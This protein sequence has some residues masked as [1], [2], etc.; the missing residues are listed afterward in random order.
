[1]SG[2]SSERKRKQTAVAVESA[3]QQ[4][5]KRTKQI[6]T[7]SVYTN[8]KNIYGKKITQNDI[9][10]YVLNNWNNK[11]YYIRESYK[12][13]YNYFKAN[14]DITAVNI[15]EYKDK[16]TDF[17]TLFNNIRTKQKTRD[18][19]NINQENS[20][21]LYFMLTN[22]KDSSDYQTL[23]NK[24]LN[25]VAI[26]PENDI[27]LDEPEK[28]IYWDIV[29]RVY[30]VH[31]LTITDS[32]GRKI[33]LEDYVV[34]KLNDL[35]TIITSLSNKRQ[36]IEINLYNVFLENIFIKD[37]RTPV[38]LKEY[39]NKYST[40]YLHVFALN[41]N[42]DILSSFLFLRDQ[43][44]WY[45]VY[46]QRFIC[47][48]IHD[49][50]GSTRGD[51]KIDDKYFHDLIEKY[52]DEIA[53]LVSSLVRNFSTLI[54]HIPS[55]R[56]NFTLINNDSTILRLYIDDEDE[57]KLINEFEFSENKNINI[58]QDNILKDSDDKF[59]QILYLSVEDA[60]RMI[61]TQ[62]DIQEHLRSLINEVGITLLPLPEK[63]RTIDYLI[64]LNQGSIPLEQPPVDGKYTK[65]F[66]ET[67]NI[68]G[69]DSIGSYSK[70]T[71]IMKLID[72]TENQS[73]ELSTSH[74]EINYLWYLKSIAGD[75]DSGGKE[76]NY[77]KQDNT[78][79][80]S[81]YNIDFHEYFE[82]VSFNTITHKH[83]LLKYSIEHVPGNK[84]KLTLKYFSVYGDINY[85]TDNST[86]RFNKNQI[87]DVNESIKYFM[88]KFLGD[89]SKINVTYAFQNELGFKEERD[90]IDIYYKKVTVLPLYYSVSGD[91]SSS[92]GAGFKLPGSVVVEL[93]KGIV[94]RNVNGSEIS[95]GDGIQKWPVRSW[96]YYD[97][98]FYKSI[99][100]IEPLKERRIM[101]IPSEYYYDSLSQF[102][103]GFGKKNKRFIK[104]VVK[105]SQRKGTQGSFSR[106][107]K[108]HHLA[109]KTGK[110][111]QRCVNA[112]IRSRNEKIRRKAQFAKN[113]GAIARKKK[114]HRRTTFGK[115]NFIKEVFAKSKRKGTS[116]SFTKWCK[117]H[118]LLSKSG[119][120][121]K[122]CINAGLK[123]RSKTVRRRAQFLKNV[124][125]KRIGNNFGKKVKRT[126]K[127]TPTDKKKYSSA[128][129]YVKARVKVWPSAYASGQV[130]KR[131]KLLGGKYS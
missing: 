20:K 21:I 131:Y 117:R 87:T 127:A 74:T 10:D 80:L 17:K 113:I 83:D 95:A 77:N 37:T 75:Y 89:E 4:K 54:K 44:R 70:Y 2:R 25:E 96:V 119:K 52:R 16:V 121:N 28:L 18:Y 62:E 32:L 88:A 58:D 69:V 84:P 29:K 64:Y 67:V 23:Y 47:D 81:K 59:Y 107:C 78:I 45:I 1:M 31:L 11:F 22:K 79:D 98:R 101:V 9:D 49:F 41:V 48:S 106:W 90:S 12:D 99:F 128:V 85:S 26:T 73:K 61:K 35:D 76:I 63:L 116:G 86:L 111:T 71:D 8:L 110:V 42:K 3:E 46:R 65:N 56:Y 40:Y 55:D 38:K 123:A 36:S 102:S 34:Q 5:V 129:R 7:D 100:Q 53:D 60:F 124:L 103:Q 108:T 97:Q 39:Y 94:I 109:S 14:P 19:P 33:Q 43:I 13:I 51:T 30:Q 126:R 82:F 24:I 66:I 92:I 105:R 68:L 15:D 115:K 57:L 6:S 27:S 112:G 104:K 72:E 93:K 114:T 118:K 91:I 50:I 130:V 120:I 125:Y 122:R